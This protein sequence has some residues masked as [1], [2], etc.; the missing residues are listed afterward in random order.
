MFVLHILKYKIIA[1]FAAV[2]QMSIVILSSD[3]GGNSA[4]T[5]EVARL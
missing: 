4:P 5:P 2:G 1:L 3:D